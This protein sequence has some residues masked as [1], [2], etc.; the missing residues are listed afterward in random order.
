MGSTILLSGVTGYI[1][2]HLAE[3]LLTDG[4]IV[5]GLVRKKSIGKA[6]KLYFAANENFHIQPYDGSEDSLN[7]IFT[8][9]KINTVIHLAAS[10]SDSSKISE[11]IEANILLGTQLLK[12]MKEFDVHNFIN[13]GTYWQYY[14]TA[15]YDPNSL[16]AATKQS[17]QDILAWFQKS[18]NINAITLTL[19]DVYGPKDNRNKIIPLLINATKLNNTIELTLGEQN[20]YPVHIQDV[21]NAYIFSVKLLE[22]HD[23]HDSVYYVAGD[24]I[25]IKNLVE[26]WVSLTGVF[27]NLKW[28]AINYENSQIMNPY[29]GKKIPGWNATMTI[30]EG[31]RSIISSELN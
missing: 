2:R 4:N 1:G 26:L 7:N 14:D 19:Y 11:L 8:L 30:Q 13:T 31:L 27:L 21:I 16:Y 6:N 12:I 5:V 3:K 28:G 18:G 9:Y 24:P 25:T 29:K 10:T 22:D 15:K 23:S 17:F 20:I